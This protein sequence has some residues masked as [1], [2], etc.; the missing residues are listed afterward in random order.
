LAYLIDT[1]IAIH[2]RDGDEAVVARALAA[3]D[4]VLMSAVTLVELEGGVYRDPR[5]ASIRRARLDQLVSAVPVLA[6]DRDAAEH[7]GRLVARTGYSRRK[8]IDRM[9]AA[10]AL[11]RRATLVTRNA[12]DYADIDGLALEVW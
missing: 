6:F 11:Q 12:R 9:I 7:Y 3:T 2:L 4:T 5:F 8:L 10:Q 1:D